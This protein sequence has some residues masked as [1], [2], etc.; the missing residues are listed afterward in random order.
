MKNQTSYPVTLGTNSRN[1]LAARCSYRKELSASNNFLT[2]NS[3]CMRRH[4]LSLSTD[5]IT[6]GEHV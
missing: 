4:S 1:G 5:I 2:G 6:G 3:I